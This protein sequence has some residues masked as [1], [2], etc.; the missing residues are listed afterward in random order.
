MGHSRPSGPTHGLDHHRFG[1]IVCLAI[2][3]KN[4]KFCG[5]WT[6]PLS[7]APPSSFEDFKKTFFFFQ[8]CFRKM[9][10]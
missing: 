1:A 10:V 9:I 8:L 7:L 3:N 6:I 2:V 5:D 4:P